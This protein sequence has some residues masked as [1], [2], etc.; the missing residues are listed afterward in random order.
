MI[1]A[2]WALLVGLAVLAVAV[3]RFDVALVAAA[4]KALC[5]GVWFMELRQAAR[6]HATLF[7]LA[8]AF[9]TSLLLLLG[10]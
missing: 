3:G 10:R 5:V 6:L 8:T 9:V 1:G 2:I 4:A 7:T